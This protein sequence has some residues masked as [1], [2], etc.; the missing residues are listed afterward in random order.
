MPA[1]TEAI[2][3]TM[4]RLLPTDG[5]VLDLFA[6]AAGGWSLGMRRAGYRI[7]AACEIDPWRRA[8]LEQR[9]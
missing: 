9:A 6:G 1:I 4:M 8:V 5:A 2:G 7:L 3:R